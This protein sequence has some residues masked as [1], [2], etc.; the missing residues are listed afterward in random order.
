[1][2]H[3]ELKM[4]F[5]ERCSALRIQ[6]GM[7]PALLKFNNSN[8]ALRR[9]DAFLQGAYDDEELIARIRATAEFGGEEFDR[10][11]EVARHRQRCDQR[12]RQLVNELHARR[13]FMPHVY[14]DHENRIPNSIFVV[15]LTG[16]RVFKILNLPDHILVIQDL[17]QRREAV[18]N[19]LAEYI[20]T[21][22]ERNLL[23]S[24][25]GKATRMLY[26]E[27]YDTYLVFDFAA[28]AFTETRE[29]SPGPGNATW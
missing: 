18:R 20:T 17:A 27:T 29:G 11:L 15:A 13:E 2:H 5:S 4:Y 12:E 6:R 21:P 7:I 1:M 28:K 19:F 16:P 22:P 3:L 14:V 26:R 24:P 23:R 9:F 25:F 10:V 8:K